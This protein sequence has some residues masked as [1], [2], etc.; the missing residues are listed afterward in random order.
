MTGLSRIISLSAR[1]GVDVYS[2]VDQ[3]QSCGSCPSYAV[4][5]ATKHDT[6]KGACCPMAVGNAL[7][8]MYKE[9]QDEISDSDETPQVVK[10]IEETPKKQPS[11]GIKCP[12]CG[13]TALPSGGC[14]MC[15]SCGW[16]KCD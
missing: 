16:T 10:K 13:A 12:Q 15:P 5:S 8:D 11:A 3:L 2:I 1:A 14:Y 9:M 4:R 6:S 7:L